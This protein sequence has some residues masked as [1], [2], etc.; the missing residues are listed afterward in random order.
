MGIVFIHVPFTIYYL[1]NRKHPVEGD[2][3]PAGRLLGDGYLVDDAPGDERVEHPREVLRR[4]AV[5]R[6][7]H[8]EV[9]REQAYLLV[10]VPRGQTAD[11]VD[12]G[13]D[14]PLGARGRLL[15]GL[16]DELGRAVQVALLDDLALA[17]RVDEH[18]DARKLF[19]DRVDVPR[20][21]A[22]VDGAVALP[23]DEPRLAQLLRRIAAQLL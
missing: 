13:A 16:D 21:E 20:A 9:G 15:D 6:G 3:R 5:H 7:A 18:L 8:A 4:D 14:R 11:E 19:A 22:P 23:E 1:L 12:L 17:L 2:A 10:R